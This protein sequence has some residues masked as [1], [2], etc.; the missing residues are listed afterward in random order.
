M[1]R[2]VEY[3]IGEIILDGGL[4]IGKLVGRGFHPSNPSRAYLLIVRDSGEFT[5]YSSL[6][7]CRTNLSL[8]R[9]IPS[10]VMRLF[11]EIIL[12]QGPTVIP[13]RE[14]AKPPVELEERPKKKYPVLPPEEPEPEQEAEEPE[15]ESRELVLAGDASTAAFDFV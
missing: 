15:E 12:E 14:P 9:F 10:Q 5:I 11:A 1:R 3:E 8:T 4:V 13:S 6:T 2:A 7:D